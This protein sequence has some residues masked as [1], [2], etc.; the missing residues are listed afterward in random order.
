MLDALDCG[1]G[2]IVPGGDRLDTFALLQP[3]QDGLVSFRVVLLER[4]ELA[5]IGRGS[6]LQLL[7]VLFCCQ[8]GD[9]DVKRGALGNRILFTRLF[10]VS[11]HTSP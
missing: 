4:G 6:P 3:V 7:F 8:R 1:G 9:Y 11:T 5:A 10:P 2:G